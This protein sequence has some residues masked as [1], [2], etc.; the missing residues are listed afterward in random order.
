MYI[1]NNKTLVVIINFHFYYYPF[2][3]HLQVL[4]FINKNIH[5]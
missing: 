4:N 5:C 2:Q 1:K 3:K